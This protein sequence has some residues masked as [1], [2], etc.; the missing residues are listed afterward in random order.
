M[1][2]LKTAMALCLLL[3][4]LMHSGCASRTAVVQTGCEIDETL[5]VKLDERYPGAN[6]PLGT[7][8]QTIPEFVKDIRG[9]NA[10]KDQLLK[11]LEKCK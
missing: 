9:D 5:I 4:I 6:A 11:Q 10:R 8:E 7:I 2:I 3:L 1:L